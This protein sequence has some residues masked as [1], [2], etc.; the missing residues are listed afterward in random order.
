MGEPLSPRPLGPGW[1]LVRDDAQGF[2]LEG[3]TRGELRRLGGLG[4]VGAMSAV[5]AWALVAATPDALEL[6]TWPLAGVLALVAALSVPAAVRTARRLALGVGLSLTPA[7]LT[8]ALVAGGLLGSGRLTVAPARVLRVELRRRE[9]GAL[10]LSSLEVCLRG[11][12]RLEGPLLAHAAGEEDPL[13]P[14]AARLAERLHA[15]L[16][17]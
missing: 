5:C 3:S 9:D 14:V 16:E 7:G 15:P 2:E 6:V 1:R 10:R 12:G 4:L 13:L 17:S 11:G 8:G